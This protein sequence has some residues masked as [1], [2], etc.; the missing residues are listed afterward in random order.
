MRSHSFAALALLCSTSA[1]A[2]CGESVAVGTFEDGTGG[3]G[4]G[5]EITSTGA[6][7]AEGGGDASS[8]GTGSEPGADGFR[9][10]VWQ[11]L[12]DA[13]TSNLFGQF[14]RGGVTPPDECVLEA[15]S[16][17]CTLH[18]CTLLDIES[19]VMVDAGTVSATS[20]NRAIVAHNDPTQ[21]YSQDF[22]SGPFFSASD[23]VSFQIAGN[24]E[25][26]AFS[27]S[28]GAPLALDNAQAIADSIVSPS[29]DDVTVTWAPRTQENATITIARNS[30]EANTFVT[31]T[32]TG[33]EGT[34]TIPG[35]LITAGADVDPTYVFVTAGN[36]SAPITAGTYTG[37]LS[38][39]DFKIGVRRCGLF[40]GDEAAECG[41]DEYCDYEGDLCGEND[42]SGVCRPR[43]ET[44]EA[45]GPVVCSCDGESYPSACEAAQH[46][47]DVWGGED[48]CIET[49]ICGGIGGLTCEADQFCDFPNDQ[50][51]GDDSTGVCRTRP[52]DCPEPNAD[53][54]LCGC[55]FDTYGSECLANQAGQDVS[56]NDPLE[57]GGA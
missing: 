17:S 24:G 25:V 11:G 22:S 36:Q 16:G 33:Q 57:C 15:T 31:C 30:E 27:G 47:A 49:T 14:N 8:S 50:C 21:G 37:T 45:D 20:G 41:D 7:P 26:P 40:G 29:G 43:P 55:N 13:E 38:A 9:L 28:I 53:E 2:A 54:V 46:G 32:V 12:L 1:L 42:G 34:L 10:T 18:R 5:E 3:A 51:G 52:T 44:C 4:G 35:S 56:L 23:P 48:F 39:V 6:S 19:Q